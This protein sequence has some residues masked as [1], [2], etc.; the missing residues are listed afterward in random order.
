MSYTRRSFFILVLPVLVFLVVSCDSRRF[1]EENKSIVNG[2]WKSN[3]RVQ[4]DVPVNDT[5]P[6]YNFFLNVRNAGDYPYS[7]LYL[8]IH[9]TAPDGKIACDTLECQLASFDG[10]WLGSGIG[11]LK[12]S[13]FFFQENVRFHSIGTYRFEI[14][15]AM[16]VKTLTG[17]HDIGIR[18]EKTMK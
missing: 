8:F 7:N 18:I 5:L 6:G 3:E 17:I 15:Q 10:K 2:V 1:F 13:R 12:F 16:R 11:N 14:E 4:F 9:T